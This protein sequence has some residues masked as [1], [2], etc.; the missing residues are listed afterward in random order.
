[1]VW[2]EPERLSPNGHLLFLPDLG[3][4]KLNL[5]KESKM[6]FKMKQSLH[7]FLKRGSFFSAV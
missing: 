1:M 2:P 3:L 6:W 5:P 7:V 4:T